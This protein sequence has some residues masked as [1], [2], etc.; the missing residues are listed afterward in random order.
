MVEEV[1]SADISKILADPRISSN[2]FRLVKKMRDLAKA[3]SI[4]DQ[5]GI[6]DFWRLKECIPDFDQLHSLDIHAFA[7]LLIAR[8]GRIVSL[9]SALPITQGMRFRH[10]RAARLEKEP[11]V[12]VLTQKPIVT[13][14]RVLLENPSP[15]SLRPTY[16]TLRFLLADRSSTDAEFKSWPSDHRAELR[17]IATFQRS[18]GSTSKGKLNDLLELVSYQ[19]SVVDFGVW[20]TSL[21]AHLSDV[22]STQ[23]PFFRSLS[24]YLRRDCAVA[25]EILPVLVHTL[26][27]SEATSSGEEDVRGI[28]SSYLSTTAR[29]DNASLACLRSVVDIVLHLRNFPI[30][31]SSDPLSHD[32]WLDLDFT[33]LSR[34]AIK[35]GAY[36][37]AL[38]FLE[39]Q[40][41]HEKGPKA[42]ASEAED[43]YY[44][45]YSH[46]E[47]PDGF[48]GIQ[49]KDLQSF[50]LR[51]FQH[52]NEWDKAFRFY[53]AAIEAEPQ[54]LNHAHGMVSALHSFGFNRLALSTLGNSTAADDPLTQHQPR[55]N[56]ELGWRTGTWD[57]PEAYHAAS[58]SASLYIALRAVHQETSSD[59]IDHT[60]KSAFNTEMKCLRQ[61]GT[62][63][64]AGIR[65][66]LQSMMCLQQV[67]EWQEAR[68]QTSDGIPWTQSDRMLNLES[69]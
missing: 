60:L 43:V 41:E 21:S 13:S 59:A 4:S 14:L 20:V 18:Y 2:K 25:E 63:N 29:N 45:I 62:E 17:Y 69:K 54:A 46:I 53:G 32:R 58:G 8:Q 15:V 10:R 24:S 38:L 55:L 6:S 56:Y 42:D 52:E 35:C 51:R 61:L 33:S 7:E 37:T 5:F 34:T 12:S 48:Y 23:R 1:T 67:A 57:L 30:P 11:S 9:G 50:L 47:E 64:I 49:T 66:V 31:R 40:A 26:L 44:D 36:T 22:L 19:S 16:Q 28:L 68:H 65:Y 27:L 3:G 39:L